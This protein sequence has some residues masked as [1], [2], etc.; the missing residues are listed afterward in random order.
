MLLNYK[1]FCK[2]LNKLNKP[3]VNKYIREKKETYPIVMF[4]I[5]ICAFA[6]KNDKKRSKT[7]ATL[8]KKRNPIE[9]LYQKYLNDPQRAAFEA[10]AERII[11]IV[12]LTMSGKTE[13]CFF[14]RKINEN[15]AFYF[16]YEENDAGEKEWYYAFVDIETDETLHHNSGNTVLLTTELHE[17]IALITFLCQFLS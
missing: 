8:A 1:N 6:V 4:F 11:D 17:K 14:E 16:D 10:E 7:Y 12:I 9:Y 13:S 2:F 15:L 3:E 5:E